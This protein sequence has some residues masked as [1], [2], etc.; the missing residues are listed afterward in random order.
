MNSFL[1]DL[2]YAARSI[3]RSVRITHIVVVTLGLAIGL[4]ATIFSGVSALL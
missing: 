4:N 2:R 1:V 3:R